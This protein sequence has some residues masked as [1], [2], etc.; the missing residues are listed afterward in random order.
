MK[1]TLSTMALVVTMLLVAAPA[2]FATHAEVSHDEAGSG[3]TEC[4]PGADNDIIHPWLLIDMD[5]FVDEIATLRD[6]T[7]EDAL[8]ALQDRAGATWDFCDKNRSSRS[9]PLRARG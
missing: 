2:A 5:G 1:R 4:R 3:T 6:I 8:A 7:D 9:P